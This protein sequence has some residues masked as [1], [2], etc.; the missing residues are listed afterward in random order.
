MNYEEAIKYIHSVGKFGSKLGLINITKLLDLLNNPQNDLKFIH[1]GGTNGKGSTCNYIAHML[2]AAGYRTGLFI[3][4]YIEKFGERMQVDFKN[5]DNRS[6]VTNVQKVKDCI[7]VMLESGYNHPTEF[8]INTAVAMLYFKQKRCDVVVLEVGLGG[9]LDST[10]VIKSPLATVICTIE[11]DHMGVLGDTLQK[12]AFEKA[13]IIKH[14]SPVV[15]YGDNEPC[16]YDVIEAQAEKTGAPYFVVNFENISNIR[17][18]DY[19]YTFDFERYTDLRIN[20]FGDYQVKNAC[21]AVKAVEA[22]K[23][24]VSEEA[25]RKGLLKAKWPGRLEVLSKNPLIICDGSHNPEAV[26]SLKNTLIKYFP[27]KKKILIMGVMKNKEY[28]KMIE[29]I[30]PLADMGIAIRTQCNRALELDIL[31]QTMQKYC[32]NTY[33]FDKIEDGLDY[34]VANADNNTVICTFGSLYYIADVKNYVRRTGL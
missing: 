29:D 1:V 6:L 32:K 24:K 7:D 26:R 4:P 23:L 21:T 27:D 30:F 16:T 20:M 8:E 22:S 28:E 31:Q 33:S 15:V 9:R 34:A 3:S 17:Y 13:G 12:I 2:H 25:I 5:I 14:A 10:N 19:G 11:K 18:S